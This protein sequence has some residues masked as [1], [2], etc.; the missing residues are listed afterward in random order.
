[1]PPSYSHPLPA[2]SGVLAVGVPSDVDLL[3]VL[4]PKSG[5]GGQDVAIGRETEPGAWPGIT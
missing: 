2:L 4:K 3:L 1:M 5:Y